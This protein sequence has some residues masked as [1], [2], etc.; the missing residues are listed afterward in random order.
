MIVWRQAGLG[1][2]VVRSGRPMV[3]G[4]APSGSEKKVARSAKPNLCSVLQIFQL[5]DFYMDRE[6]IEIRRIP[7]RFPPITPM[8]RYY[9]IRSG[10]RKRC[11]DAVL[12][13]RLV[14]PWEWIDKD[15]EPHVW[16]PLTA[17]QRRH[18]RFI[19]I[20]NVMGIR[21]N[22]RPPLYRMRPGEGAVMVVEA[23]WPTHQAS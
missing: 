8:E 18:G 15:V 6:I 10:L 22:D 12:R 5:V 4:R 1:R 11:P 21:F 17:E 3:S 9:G 20:Y 7:V 13:T 16:R 14:G 19:P 2:S 23:R